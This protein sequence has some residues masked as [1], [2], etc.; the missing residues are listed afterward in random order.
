MLESTA[1]EV[2][3]LARALLWSTPSTLA[4]TPIDSWRS[5]SSAF[6]VPL[7]ATKTS[8]G[9]AGLGTGG[10]FVELVVAMGAID[11]KALQALQ[12]SSGSKGTVR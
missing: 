2:P 1:P 12:A 10:K 4:P 11:P 5:Q 7:E 6:P 9:G 8:G 3:L